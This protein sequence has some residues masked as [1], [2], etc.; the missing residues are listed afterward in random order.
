MAHV[1]MDVEAVTGLGHQLQ[2]QADAINGVIS[3]VDGIVRQLESVWQGNDA[4]QFAEWW[5]TQHKPALHNA[6]EAVRGLGQ[7]A[8]NNASDQAATSG[9]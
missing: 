2:S 7:S 1:G 5:N 4:R 3:A 8:L 6:E 9:R